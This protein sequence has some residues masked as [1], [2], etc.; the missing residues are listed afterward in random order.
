MAKKEHI[1]EQIMRALRQGE[2]GMRVADICR[3]H[4]VSEATFYLRK[5]KIQRPGA[6]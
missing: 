4:G 2:G 6:E 5:K 3:E 1:E